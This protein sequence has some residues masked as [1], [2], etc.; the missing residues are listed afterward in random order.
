MRAWWAVPVGMILLLVG[1][2]WL[3]QGIGLLQG[4]FMSD[5]PLWALIGVLTMGA[6]GG[7]LYAR[8]R[9]RGSP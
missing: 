8:M 7:M 2:V 9:G 4:S 6:G 1:A 5:Q 3:L